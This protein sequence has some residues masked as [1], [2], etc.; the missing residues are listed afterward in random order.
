MCSDNLKLERPHHV[1]WVE[2]LTSVPLMDTSQ[3]KMIFNRYN[4]DNIEINYIFI[5]FKQFM[6]CALCII[7]LYYHFFFL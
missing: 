6:W 1:L 2:L 7:V 3:S 4:I 5:S